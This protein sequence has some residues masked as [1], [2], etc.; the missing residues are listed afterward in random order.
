VEY[1]TEIFTK[2]LPP[3]LIKFTSY[4]PNVLFSFAQMNHQTDLWDSLAPCN[5][6]KEIAKDCGGGDGGSSGQFFFFNHNKTLILKTISLKER[7]VFLERLEYFHKHFLAHPQS[8]IVKM[9]SIVSVLNTESEDEVNFC[10]M[11][12]ILR[13]INRKYV[14]R[15][16][17]LKGSLYSRAVLKGKKVKQGER[18]A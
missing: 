13:G 6:E 10:L 1:Y 12:N 14:I 8:L 2:K 3:V 5:N 17:D 15:S 16:Y 7:T 11:G 4:S 18:V 9:Y